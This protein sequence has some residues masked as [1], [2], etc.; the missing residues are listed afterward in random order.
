MAEIE[1]SR[2]AQ[3]ILSCLIN[4]IKTYTKNF[5]KIITY[6]NSCTRQNRNIKTVLNLL[7]PVQSIEIKTQSIE[8]KY[9]VSE[10]SYLPSDLE[11]A[12][13]K[14][15]A[16][17]IKN[18]FSPDDWNNTIKKCKNKAPFNLIQMTHQDLFLTKLLKNSI[19]NR[20]IIVT[21]F[22]VNRLKMRWI[23]LE[24]NPIQYIQM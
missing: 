14:S 1:G 6:S 19:I 20:K 17:K 9:L 8:M 12:I 3:E 15:H 24:S 21:G 18:I 10:H 11:F 13:I 23:K 16:K 4:Y 22:P 7:K 2:G 5:E